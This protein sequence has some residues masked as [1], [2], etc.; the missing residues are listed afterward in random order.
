MHLTTALIVVTVVQAAHLVEE[1]R[2][3]FRRQY[4]FGVMPAWVM[5]AANV[6]LYTGAAITIALSACD[7]PL[8]MTLAW[9]Y[10]LVLLGN[11]L[12][13]IGIMIL[14]RRYFPGGFTAVLLLP[15]LAYL[16]CQLLNG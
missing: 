13:H 3:G 16:G 1:I 14:R 15:A 7:Q 4:P 8:T 9:I 6:L 10:G 5:V 12:G 2:T 11:A